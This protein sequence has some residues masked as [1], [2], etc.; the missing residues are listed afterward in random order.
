MLEPLQDTLPINCLVHFNDSLHYWPR[1]LR[2]FQ[3][4]C[5]K[6]DAVRRAPNYMWSR[7]QPLWPYL[8]YQKVTTSEEF[9]RIMNCD[10]RWSKHS[11]YVAV[12]TTVVGRAEQIYHCQEQSLRQ[13]LEEI[14]AGKFLQNQ[15][16]QQ[17]SE[18]VAMLSR[19]DVC[20]H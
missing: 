19:A 18:S 7:F 20:F 8:T 3:P 15:S 17:C 1:K 6:T 14:Y 11:C 10:F 13:T 5:L 4:I 16:L 12:E 9:L 2:L